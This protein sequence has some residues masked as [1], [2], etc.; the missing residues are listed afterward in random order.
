[1]K[2]ANEHMTSLGA[3][4]KAARSVLGFSQKEIAESA[5]ISLSHYSQI[6]AGRRLPSLEV[7]INIS[8]SLKVSPDSLVYGERMATHQ[9]A[10]L[11]MLAD[12]SD[13]ELLRIDQLLHAI[14][15]SNMS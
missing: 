4:I 12:L 10:I 8:E 1:M 7:F 9:D 5:G 13:A 15:R 11:Q 14:M 6:E 3:N 2:T